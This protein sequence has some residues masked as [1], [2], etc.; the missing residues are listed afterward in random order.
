MIIN[1]EKDIVSIN[2]FIYE[3]YNFY[4]LIV[5]LSNE[6]IAINL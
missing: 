6:I 4:S 1:P 3:E 5:D 2:K